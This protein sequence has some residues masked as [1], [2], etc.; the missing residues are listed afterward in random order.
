MKTTQTV[1][2]YNQQKHQ[3]ATQRITKS[4]NSIFWFWSFS[5]FLLNYMGEHGAKYLAKKRK[6]DGKNGA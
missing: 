1:S 6:R 4:D 5:N 3:L 2:G